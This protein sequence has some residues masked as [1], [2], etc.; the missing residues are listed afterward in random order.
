M[1]CRARSQ[2]QER[3]QATYCIGTSMC[4]DLGSR[5][6]TCREFFFNFW[7]FFCYVWYLFVFLLSMRVDVDASGAY[8]GGVEQQGLDKDLF[9]VKLYF[10][11]VAPKLRNYFV[12]KLLCVA[13]YLS[14]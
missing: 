8:K 14:T 4:Y 1:A 10:E 13:I 7:I 11:H 5:Q 6:D 2:Q 12:F 3:V 9:K